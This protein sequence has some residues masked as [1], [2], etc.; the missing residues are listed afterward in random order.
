MSFCNI[1]NSAFGNTPAFDADS[2]DSKLKSSRAEAAEVGMEDRV[3]GALPAAAEAGRP[4]I[5]EQPRRESSAVRG[6]VTGQ[7]KMSFIILSFISR[8]ATATPLKKQ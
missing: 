8:A 2:R 6:S 1:L 7:Q 4:E 5:R 3:E